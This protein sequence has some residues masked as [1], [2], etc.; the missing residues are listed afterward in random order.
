MSSHF[1]ELHL[2][3]DL[4]PLSQLLDQIGFG[5]ILLSPLCE[6]SCS[7][8]CTEHVWCDT[9]MGAL[10]CMF[11]IIHYLL[12]LCRATS[13]AFFQIA[14][15]SSA[16]FSFSAIYSQIATLKIQ[17]LIFYKGL[18]NFGAKYWWKSE[19]YSQIFPRYYK[20]IILVSPS[21]TWVLPSIRKKPGYMENL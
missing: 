19:A 3:H 17:W 2:W 18:W 9:A 11:W 7:C 4:H 10:R 13:A 15:N 5:S 16:V 12:T 6:G 21:I 8:D 14:L 1:L 20:S